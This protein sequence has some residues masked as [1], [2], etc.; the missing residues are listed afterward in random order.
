MGERPA[1]LATL[2]QGPQA[3]A[4]MYVDA[5]SRV[6]SLGG[7]RLLDANVEREARGL[8]VQG[9]S[10]VRSYGEDGATLGRGC[11]CTWPPSPSRRGW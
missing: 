4:K 7:P 1:A 10:T 2:L 8:V 6:G 3:G 5:E 11:G 9:Q